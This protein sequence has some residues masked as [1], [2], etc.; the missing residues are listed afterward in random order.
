[1]VPVT[2]RTL[3]K[4]SSLVAAGLLLRRRSAGG[5]AVRAQADDPLPEEASAPPL[6]GLPVRWPDGCLSWSPRGNE[7]ALAA[8]DPAKPLSRRTY[9]WAVPIDGTRARRVSDGAGSAAMPAWSPDGSRL[10]F[11]SNRAGTCDIYTMRL[12]GTE[13]VRLTS[14]GGQNV[15]PAWSPDGTSLAFA[16][17]RSEHWQIWTMDVDGGSPRRLTLSSSQDTQPCWSPDGQS[18]V[19][20]SRPTCSGYSAGFRSIIWTRTDRS[21]A[22]ALASDMADCHSPARSPDGK[23]MAYVSDQTGRSEVRIL[24]LA[25]GEDRSA[26]VIEGTC[27]SPTWSPDG[28]DLAYFAWILPGE[29]WTVRADGSEARSLGCLEARLS[30]QQ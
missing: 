22:F 19:F 8:P 9:I 25:S 11:V 21:D 2:R 18:I 10:A 5:S 28:S 14:D 4:V 6:L 26:A 20:S 3:V 12:D 27:T 1:M 7:M 24:D 15:H 29:I 13:V 30:A 23:S 16:S 17:D